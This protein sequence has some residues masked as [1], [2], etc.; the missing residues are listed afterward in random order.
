MG[1]VFSGGG[2]MEESPSSHLDLRGA[3]S[4]NRF[5]RL[6]VIYAIITFPL[7]P[8]PPYRKGSSEQ[9]SATHADPNVK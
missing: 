4:A 2:R 9:L 6:Y 7:V 5:M 1:T 3:F 8:G